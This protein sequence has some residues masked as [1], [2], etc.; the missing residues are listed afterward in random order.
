M[1]SSG[2]KYYIRRWLRRRLVRPLDRWLSGPPP[3][4]KYSLATRRDARRMRE[5]LLR[6]LS[7]ELPLPTHALGSST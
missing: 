2:M 1:M 4:R 5:R 6:R 7:D 3:P